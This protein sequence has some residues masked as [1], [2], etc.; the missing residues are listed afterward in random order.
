MG[1]LCVRR[2]QG[3][4][5][6]KDSPDQLLV[7]A[8]QVKQTQAEN[9]NLL[10]HPEPSPCLPLSPRVSS[11]HIGYKLESA[12][13]DWPDKCYHCTDIRYQR[14]PSPALQRLPRNPQKQRSPTVT[15]RSGCCFSG[16]FHASLHIALC[17]LVHQMVMNR[18]WGLSAA[19]FTHQPARLRRCAFP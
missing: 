19:V 5:V 2:C 14:S 3:K 9:S 8:S 16:A 1:V 12:A 18:P 11:F 4:A 7:P 15:E 6:A 10:V 17:S 13:P